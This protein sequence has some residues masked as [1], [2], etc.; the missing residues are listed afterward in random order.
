M[1]DEATI[2]FMSFCDAATAYEQFLQE[3]SADGLPAIR[4]SQN[5]AMKEVAVELCTALY[6]K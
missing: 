4:K 1:Q 5:D 3:A 2:M 6:S